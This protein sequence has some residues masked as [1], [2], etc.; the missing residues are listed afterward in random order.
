MRVRKFIEDIEKMLSCNAIYYPR[1][2]QVVV[3]ININNKDVTLCYDEAFIEN[4]W[5]TE[6]FKVVEDDL[7]RIGSEVNT[8]KIREKTCKSCKYWN[9]D[10][11]YCDDCSFTE[12]KW[13]DAHEED[14]HEH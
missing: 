13:E 9:D 8:G 5:N 6:V 7:F 1:E 4:N 11:G 2:Q 10:T 3:V 14:A 12:S